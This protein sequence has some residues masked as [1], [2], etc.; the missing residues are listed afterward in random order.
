MM[1]NFTIDEL[2]QQIRDA[3]LPSSKIDAYV[4]SLLKTVLCSD[5]AVIETSELSAVEDEVKVGTIGLCL[6]LLMRKSRGDN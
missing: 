3:I 1:I 5:A 4:D 6:V 2:K